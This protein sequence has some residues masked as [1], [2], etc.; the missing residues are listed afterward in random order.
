MPL[1][2]ASVTFAKLFCD[3]AECSCA[4]MFLNPAQRRPSSHTLC[5]QPYLQ[6]PNIH[7]PV[8][9]K[10]LNNKV[11][12]QYCE[13]NSSLSQALPLFTLG[14]DFTAVGPRIS[15]SHIPN[16]DSCIQHLCPALKI[17]FRENRHRGFCSLLIELKNY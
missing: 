8:S 3:V 2:N 11:C 9:L 15:S 16:S 6:H 17:T 13:S 5:G 10:S 4:S 7:H 12:T 1:S 14:T